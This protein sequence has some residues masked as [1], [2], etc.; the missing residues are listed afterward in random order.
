M[1]SFV[2]V[3]LLGLAALVV[4]G[5]LARTIPP[6]WCPDLAWLVVV[7]VGLRWP[8][9]LSGLMVSLPLGYAMDLLSGSLMG[10]HAL[11]RLISYLTAAV[12]SR[13]LDMSGKRSVAIF[14][15]GMTFIYALGIAGTGSL[16]AGS[17]PLGW[18]VLSSTL[19][20]AMANLV[21]A[22]PMIAMVDWIIT[23]STDEE[24]GRQA[25]IALS[26]SRGTLL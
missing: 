12:A 19:A 24:A 17:S 22:G 10:Q 8:G 13:Q 26:G 7:G 2:A 1:K 20:H 5:A 14:V 6:P 11:M 9:F 23:F 18:D 4:Q 16:F 25:P 21:A 15:V 3:L